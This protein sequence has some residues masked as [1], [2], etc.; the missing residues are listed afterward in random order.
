M[1]LVRAARWSDG[2][3]S[4]SFFLNSDPPLRCDL[5]VEVR[6]WVTARTVSH[7]CHCSSKHGAM[8]GSLLM[9]LVALPAEEAGEPSPMLGGQLC[10]YFAFLSV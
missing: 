10:P 4:R 5:T 8:P 1:T 3:N 2:V 7:E 6:A 9:M